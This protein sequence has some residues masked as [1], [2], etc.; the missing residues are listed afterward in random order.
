ML[1]SF[2]THNPTHSTPCLA[3]FSTPY[4]TLGSPRSFVS[5]CK[6]SRQRSRVRVSSSPPFLFKNLPKVLYFSA[7]TKRHKIGTGNRVFPSRAYVSCVFSRNKSA[8]TASCAFR[9]SVVTACVYVSR[10]TRIVEWRSSSCMIFSSAPVD[11]SS[12]E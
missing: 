3:R 5:C 1:G 4:A 10:V 6:L 7:G 12:I 2:P 11:R 8:T 9:F